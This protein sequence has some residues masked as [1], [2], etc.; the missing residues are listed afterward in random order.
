MVNKYSKLFLLTAKF[1]NSAKDTALLVP[2]NWKLEGKASIQ[3]E[4]TT[5]K[6]QEN[7]TTKKI[8]TRKVHANELH[9][10]LG[11][12]REYRMRAT[13]KHLQYSIKGRYRFVRT[14]LQRKSNRNCY[15]K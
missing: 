8:W 3:T 14:A 9:A 1:Y 7:T 2:E 5:V 15:T 12:P 10:N 6:K 11:H 13:L 4:V